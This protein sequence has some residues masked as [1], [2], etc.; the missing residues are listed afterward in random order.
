M[1][2]VRALAILQVSIVLVLLLATAFV[3]VHIGRVWRSERVADQVAVES[4]A[5]ASRAGVQWLREF[6]RLPPTSLDCAGRNRHR[7]G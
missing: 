5:V 3:A 2:G 7:A 4:P 6:M 1:A